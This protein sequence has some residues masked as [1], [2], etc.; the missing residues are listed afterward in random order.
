MGRVGIIGPG[1]AG[2]NIYISCYLGYIVETTCG[3][4]EPGSDAKKKMA[5]RRKGP[6]R[7]ARMTF[8]SLPRGMRDGVAGRGIDSMTRKDDRTSGQRPG[9]RYQLRLG[10]NWLT[11]AFRGRTGDGMHGMKRFRLHPRQPCTP[12]SDCATSGWA[13]A[14][15]HQA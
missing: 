13:R 11:P 14:N 1:K 10:H 8:N 4:V 12:S 15:R 3:R 5:A 6:H 2:F 9:S 7:A